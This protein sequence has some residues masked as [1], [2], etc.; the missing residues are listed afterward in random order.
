MDAHER[1]DPLRHGG[2]GRRH[3]HRLLDPAA[4]AGLVRAEQARAQSAASPIPGAQSAVLLRLRKRARNHT[5]KSTP[6]LT[7][8]DA[9]KTAGPRAD[10]RQLH[11][12]TLVPGGEHVA[13]P[14]DSRVRL[15]RTR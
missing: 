14:A 9:N 5:N 10:L 6:F 13:I 2:A 3:S 15:L 1:I 4:E 8:S 7:H 11:G 12:G